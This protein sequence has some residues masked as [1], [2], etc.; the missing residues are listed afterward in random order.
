MIKMVELLSSNGLSRPGLV[1]KIGL[2]VT[3]SEMEVGAEHAQDILREVA[4]NL[5]SSGLVIVAPV[6]VANAASA[7]AAAT[8]FQGVD[9]ICAVAATWS[10]D[11]HIQDLLAYMNEPVPVIAWALP[12]LHTGSLCGTQ[13]LCCVLKELGYYYKFVYG[14]A[15]DP[16][17]VAKVRAMSFASSAKRALRFSRIARIGARMAGMAEVAVDELEMR[18]IFGVRL[19]ERGLNWLKEKVDAV[20]PAQATEQWHAVCS[21]AARVNVPDDEGLLAMKHYLALRDFVREEDVNAL[22]IECYPRL[23]GRVCVPMALL[24]EE[25]VVGACEGDV[26][27]ALAMRLLSWFTEKPVHNTDILADYPD[28]NA[29][30]FSHCGS[31]AFC[32]SG[33]K[34]DVVLDSCRLSNIGVT[35]HYPGRPG[36]VT[37]VNLVGR[38]G[39]YRLSV[40]CGEAMETELVF[41]GNP[42]KVRLDVPMDAFL[43]DVAELGLG[44]HWMIGE[45]DACAHLTEF[46]RLTG[47]PVHNPGQL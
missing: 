7:C 31:G 9:A 25:G 29:A 41:P 38:K 11:H 12:G 39:T 40:V 45:G 4:E 27:G 32:L 3:V 20:D 44:H 14:H 47:I 34:C 46:G 23:M 16:A 15:S 36:R 26:N 2:V 24:A 5:N 43:D 1:P 18:S 6:V 19:I 35:V 28:E 10:E 8:R 33:N 21:L 42:V 17:A 13:Q 22:T 30:V 37:L